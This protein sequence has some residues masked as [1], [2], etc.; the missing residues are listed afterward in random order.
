M[1][2]YK[3]KLKGNQDNDKYN[4]AYLFVDTFPGYVNEVFFDIINAEE[5][6]AKSSC[7]ASIPDATNVSGC[8]LD[9]KEI[10]K[11]FTGLKRS[12]TP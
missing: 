7:F 8:L 5:D 6:L 11:I 1:F 4:K 10:H 12:T 9:P 3:I 2:S